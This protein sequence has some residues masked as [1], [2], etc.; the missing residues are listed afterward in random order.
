MNDLN[1][2]LF[3]IAPFL[4]NRNYPFAD[5]CSSVPSFTCDSLTHV[6]IVVDVHEEILAP[7]RASF[8][9]VTKHHPLELHAQGSLRSEQRHTRLR[10]SPIAL[11]VVAGNT[12]SNDVHGRVISATRTREDGVQGQLNDGLLL[13]AVLTT[14]LVAYVDPQPLHPRSFAATADVDVSA[15][16][17][18]RRHWKRFTRRMQHSI[19]V[20]FLNVNR[21][22]EGHDHSARDTDGAERLVSLV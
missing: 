10:R 5:Q 7:L 16:P 18:H 13:A 20:E 19:A 8:S 14:V 12:R 9:V 17:N 6:S 22:L 11:A 1:S 21:V 15:T 4:P 2:F 3:A